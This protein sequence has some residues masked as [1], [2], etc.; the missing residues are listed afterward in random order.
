MTT[1]L[2]ILINLVLFTLIFVVTDKR[3]VGLAEEDLE[4]SINAQEENYLKFGQYKSCESPV[5]CEKQLSG[6]ELERDL[7]GNYKLD[8]LVHTAIGDR[9]LAEAKHRDEKVLVKF[10]SSRHYK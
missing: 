9:F 5:D 8:V 6:L 4:A 2:L 7:E 10:D 3:S 1:K